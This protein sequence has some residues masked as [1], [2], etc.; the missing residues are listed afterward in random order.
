M[1]TG[2]RK[3]IR[4]HRSNLM[5]E[6]QANIIGEEAMRPLIDVLHAEG[7]GCLFFYARQLVGWCVAFSF[8]IALHG[9]L[10]PRSS[11]G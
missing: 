2:E 9:A 6:I 4:T 5:I 8:R 10:R 3:T 7:Y 11:V 1:V